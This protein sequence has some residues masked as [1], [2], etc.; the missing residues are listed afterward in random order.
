MKI[1]LGFN[2]LILT[3]FL[4][5][6]IDTFY[7]HLFFKRP[8]RVGV[9]KLKAVSGTR[10]STAEQ[11][12]DDLIRTLRNRSTVRQ[13]IF[14]YDW[15]S[16]GAEEVREADEKEIIFLLYGFVREKKDSLW[17]QPRV[18]F[19]DSNLATNQKNLRLALEPG[20]GF[21]QINLISLNN[22]QH[23]IIRDY[24]DG[25][26]GYLFYTKE[27]YQSALTFF[28]R[29]E[30]PNDHILFLTG[31]ALYLCGAP[32]DTVLAA[33]ARTLYYNREYT[34]AYFNTGFIYFLNQDKSKAE[35]LLRQTLKLDP[36]YAF[37]YYLLANI[38]R[39]EKKY[40][41]ALQI[42]QEA[43]AFTIEFPEFYYE[44]GMFLWERDS[45]SA[46]V[47]QFEFSLSLDSVYA[48]A[49]LGLAKIQAEWGNDSLSEWLFLQ[50]STLD[51]QNEE[52]LTELAEF[53]V[54][55]GQWIKLEKMLLTQDFF[56]ESYY[57]W[58]RFNLEK[59][60][61][62]K[63]KTYFLKMV[64]ND[65]RHYFSHAFLG[66]VNLK[67]GAY[68]ESRKNLKLAIEINDDCS[69]PY[70]ILGDL[71]TEFDES[72][73]LAIY[74]KASQRIDCIPRLKGQAF[75]RLGQYYLKKSQQDSVFKY[76]DLCQSTLQSQFEY[77]LLYLLALIHADRFSAAQG[78]INEILQSPL[79]PQE[80]EEILKTKR[81]ILQPNPQDSKIFRQG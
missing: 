39:Q 25:L 11:I 52:F 44:F 24:I 66:S 9:G 2:L 7:L 72:T 38:Y 68:K 23:A 79:S 49:Y 16:L 67:L 41:L 22:E 26:L 36:S 47:Q 1:L 5:I 6:L 17:I 74:Y 63:A 32:Q 58:G 69:L 18:F 55:T 70:L 75:L 73:G 14:V 35:L 28:K 56:N 51:P 78:Y 62:E 48:P 19:V 71:E 64:K 27:E 15:D 50:A 4:L 37:A 42:Y 54:N 31:N 29:V 81:L 57:F 46:A 65:P 76:L 45:L 20:E 3:G 53:Y 80:R 77:K 33:Y 30:S 12:T 61:L 43:Q 59:G 10:A 8:L 40:D 13:P 60:K 21:L 34:L